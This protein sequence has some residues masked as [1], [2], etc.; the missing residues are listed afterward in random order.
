MPKSICLIETLNLE[1]ILEVFVDHSLQLYQYIH[2]VTPTKRLL[3]QSCQL[4]VR[5]GTLHVWLCA[6]SRLR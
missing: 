6:S 4:N 3:N 1:T 5:L 2:N